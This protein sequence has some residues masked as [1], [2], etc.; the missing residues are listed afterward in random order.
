MENNFIFLNHACIRFDFEGTICYTDPYELNNVS[1]DADI[2]FITHGHFDHYS[3]Q[4]IFKV[5]KDSTVFVIPEGVA[6]PELDEASIVRVKPGNT[7]EVKEITLET[8]P[9]YNTG[10]PFHPK[11]EGWVGYV[12]EKNAIRYYVA[13][14]TDATPENRQVKCDVAFV[15]VGGKYTMNAEEAAQLVNE[16]KPSIAVPIHYGNVIGSEEDARK[17]ESLIADSIQCVFQ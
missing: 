10:K 5:G 15:P 7:Y 4:D 8:I 17:F 6:T 14:D 16:L 1:N 13:G 12:I 3:I 9:A 11:E 2:I